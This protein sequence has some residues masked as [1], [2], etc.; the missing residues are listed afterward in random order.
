MK[1]VIAFAMAAIPMLL[2]SCGKNKEVPRGSGLIEATEVTVSAESAG[3]LV[4]L[5]VDEGTVVAVGD[6]LAM[7]DTATVMLRLRQAK[8]AVEAAETKLR[9]AEVSIKQ[10]ETNLELANKEFERM[11]TLIKKG[12]VTQ[13]RYDQA[14]TA[15]NQARLAREQAQASRTATM[16]ELD[17]ARAQVDLLQKQVDDSFPES[18][19][20]GTVVEKFIERGELVG[21]GKALVRIARLDTV[22]VKIYVPP[23]DL[24]RISLGGNALVDPE[25]GRSAPL[26]GIVSW[27]SSEAEFT[28]KNVQTRESRAGLLYAVK[29]SIPNPNQVLKI[30][31][32]VAVEIR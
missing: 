3:R 23:S 22:S 1:S 29:I 19:V 10:A 32:P 2:I 28:P 4:G 17:N 26:S 11:A 5:R 30:G 15:L 8:A 24:T 21:P 18:P 9:V 12:T 6:T 14:E 27:I 13:Q 31:M 20:G 16:A 25:D 7:I